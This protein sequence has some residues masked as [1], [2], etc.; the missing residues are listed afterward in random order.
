MLPLCMRL[1]LLPWLFLVFCATA[2]AQSNDNF[3]ARLSLSGIHPIAVSNNLHATRETGEPN[4]AGAAAGRSLWWTWVAPASGV[5]NFCTYNSA[6]TA[7][8]TRA[9]AVYTGDTVSS[10][11]EIA[12]SNNLTQQYYTGNF[13]ISTYAPTAFAGGTSVSVP[14]T[15]GTTYQIAVDALST[16]FHVFGDDGTVVLSIN[17]PPTILSAANVAGTTG[18]GFSYGI[19][20]SNGPTAY[21]ATNLPPGL[22]IN[23]VT[24]VISGTPAAAGTSAIGLSA[25]GPGGTGTANLTLIVSNPV[26]AAPVV[27]VIGSAAAAQGLVGTA[28]SYSIYASG[29]PTAYTAGN[30]PAGLSLAASTGVISGT[31]TAAGVTSVPLSATGPVGTGTATL[32][33]TVANLPP[34]PIVS[35][36]LAASGTTGSS[37]S[38]SI[39]TSG[40]SLTATAATTYTAS[41]LPP[42]LTFSTTSG[43]LSG[44]PTQAGVYPVAFTVTNPGG[45][46]AATV[47]V[48]IADPAPATAPVSQPAPPVLNSNA[49]ATGIVGTAFSYGLTASNTPTSYTA[50]NLPPGFTFDPSSGKFTGT[51][52]TAG[53]F[54]VTVSATNGYGISPG[55]LTITVFASTAAQTA[56]YGLARPVVTSPAA[57]SAPVGQS[58]SY[59]ITAG[60]PGS[61]YLPY[62]NSNW[63]YSATGLPPGLSVTSSTN[64]YGYGTISGTPTTA[65][66]YTATITVNSTASTSYPSIYPAS[67]GTAVVTFTIT[68]TT[69][70]ALPV[71]TVGTDIAFTT[72]SSSYYTVTATGSPT[73]FTAT[74]LPPGLVMSAAGDISGTPT[75]TGTYPATVSATNAVGT[76]SATVTCL[77]TATA[78]PVINGS[79]VTQGTVG[80][81]FGYSI[82]ASNASTGYTASNLPPGLTLNA[83]TGSIN[84][85]PTAAGTYTVPVSATNATGTANVTVTITVVSGVPRVPTIT[86]AAV[87]QATLGQSFYYYIQ[88]SETAT[89]Y[90][91]SN[92]P[93]GLSLASGSNYLTGI[94]TAAGTYTVP[95]SATN[96][97]GTANATLTLIVSP[98][99]VPV[100]SSPAVL[101]LT[102]GQ[103]ISYYN[104]YATNSPTGYTFSGLPPGVTASTSSPGQ[105]TGTPTAAGTYSVGVTATNMT[106]MATATLTITVAP[107]TP[108]AVPVVTSAAGATGIV[109]AAF[110]YATQASVTPTAY[111]I[112]TPPPGL[113]FNTATGVLSGTP[114]AAGTYTFT[115]SATNASGTGSGTV[116]LVVALG[117]ASVPV[118]N[119]PASVPGYYNE[120][121]CYVVTATNSPTSFAAAGLPPGLGFN[122]ATGV[123]S[124]T[125]TTASG[126][127]YAVTLTATNS[128]GSSQATLTLVVL[129]TKSAHL[130]EHIN[131]AASAVFV[132]GRTASYVITDNWTTS[133]FTA[134]PLPP[135]LSFNQSTGV[136]S[137]TP[138]QSG[139]T[140]VSLSASVVGNGTDS[141]LLTIR[142]LPSTNPTTPLPDITSAVGV[143]GYAQMPFAFAVTGTN[144]PTSYAATGLPNGLTINPATGVISG[145]STD[146]GRITATITLANAA[147]S[148]SGTLSFYLLASASPVVALT[149]P[150]A[151][152]GYVGLT[153]SYAPSLAPFSNAWSEIVTNPPP[154][155]S[156]ASGSTIYGV[157]T[158][159]GTYITTV[160][161]DDSNYGKLQTVPVTFTILASAPQPVFVSAAG[162]AGTVGS[163]FSYVPSASNGPSTYTASGLPAGLTFNA[164]NDTI[165]GTPT[166][167]GTFPI[168]L[169][170]TNASGTGNAT[171]TLVVAPLVPPAPTI[172]SSDYLERTLFVGG[173]E[174]NYI[175]TDSGTPTAYAASGLPP[176]LSVNMAPGYISGT[177]TTA[178]TYPVTISASNATG[179]AS[180]VITYVISP[181]S[182]SVTPPVFS[183]LAATRVGYTGIAFASSNLGASGY[184]TSYAATGL[185][186]GLSLDGP[187]GLLTGT[188]TAVGQYTVNL[189]A[190]N[191]AGTGTAVWTVIIRDPSVL[192][193]VFSYPTTA[194]T[195]ATV[196]QPKSFTIYSVFNDG[197]S[198]VYAPTAYTVTGLPP[199]MATATANY[200]TSSSV[201]T[202]SGTPTAAGTFPVTVSATGP[203]NNPARAV[204][205]F[206]VANPAAPTIYSAAGVSGNVNRAFNYSIT[207]GGTVTSYGAGTLPGGLA[208]NTVTGVI[209]GTPTTAGT[210]SVPLMV[211]GAGGTTSGTVTIRIDPPQFGGLPLINSAAAI[212]SQA[213]PLSNYSYYSY[214]PY[215]ASLSLSYAITAINQP[216]SFSAQNLPAGLGLDPATGVISGQPLATGVFQVPISATNAAGT[217]RAVLTIIST[218]PLPVL[219]GSLAYGGYVGGYGG[220]SVSTTL[221]GASPYSYFYASPSYYYPSLGAPDPLQYSATGLPPGLSIDAS[222]GSISGTFTQAGTYPVTISATN[223]AGTGRLVT[224]FAIAA[225]APTGTVMPTPAAPTFYGVSAEALGYV[226]LPLSDTLH[227]TPTASFAASGLPA[228][229]ALNPATGAITG[230][231]PVAGTYPVMVSATN[232]GGTTQA[233]LTIIVESAP[234]APTVTSACAASAN[235]GVSFVYGIY[236]SNY[237]GI[238]AANVYHVGTLPAGLTL[239]AVTGVISGTPMGPTGVF[240]VPLSVSIGTVATTNC[241]LTLSILPAPALPPMPLL[242]SP[243]GSLALIGNPFYYP[244]QS[245]AFAPATALPAGLTYD[246]VAGTIS[247]YPTTPGTYTIPLT[248]SWTTDGTSGNTSLAASAERTRAVHGS[249]RQAAIR[250]STVSSATASTTLTASLALRVA[251]PDLSLPRLL[252]A[253]V[254]GT[255]SEGARMVFTA[256]AVGVP[257]PSYQWRHNGTLISGASDATLVLDPVQPADTG[258]YTVSAIN[259]AGSVTSAVAALLVQTTYADWQAD[260]FTA[261]EIAAGLAAD[262]GEPRR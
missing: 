225:S 143:G 75:A 183:S 199:G 176:G 51:P 108:P 190:T 234:P 197:S 83:T 53:T 186:P 3:A 31:P 251:A 64:P 95:I 169:T 195:T 59:G 133:T 66:T 212:S 12:S 126:A 26:A 49:T 123:I 85:T 258:N 239:N 207:S 106:G 58:F 37:F 262:N 204:I 33:I 236:A 22:E 50:S 86:S 91:A 202:F 141:G 102:V 114:T 25:T 68:P 111:A 113:S 138:T 260:H 162:A 38:Y 67:S 125:P 18:S 177:A 73:S 94:P 224:T 184:P 205:T 175:Y 233:V 228:W 157:P 6:A 35:S 17:A 185:P 248:A 47:T 252:A 246:P 217:S 63:T 109:G 70:G 116:N 112:D 200:A 124:G 178:G 182:A 214:Y 215:V 219:Q 256:S 23:P 155:L 244:L 188:P 229:L 193:P 132:V 213:F 189:S 232:A 14:V 261:Q 43:V 32:T 221:P 4:H 40:S 60:Y 156:Y 16:P 5:V 154:G 148:T 136:I 201:L 180:A 161:I 89:G 241:L 61:P 227:A 150:A 98:P 81:S 77:V 36:A 242:S 160:E 56:A 57:A 97:S 218:A 226:G 90:A 196:G 74:G 107:A 172:S 255:V 238:P 7:P 79:A 163:A 19:A 54:S 171:L 62:S 151:A 243:A 158:T 11:T 13:Y 24:G 122:T 76:A 134:S 140:K 209:S 119:S 170:V 235:L 216:T 120:P 211:T 166:V 1:L 21:A 131:S 135:G 117:P 46:R 191:A 253:P 103:P 231:P 165:T 34:P 42:G 88:T 130:P 142:V 173:S 237:S 181:A 55:T 65:G 28:F 105:L 118:I 72:G 139:V 149:S 187:T 153:L 20:A 100:F 48:T 174:S 15:A 78:L 259:A 45:T 230:T 8:I 137:G 84:G 167:A 144:T 208:L 168:S 29:S 203:G 164:T 71:I 101:A 159:A 210:S 250:R 44:T 82:N 247:G 87:A 206:V 127:S 147:G 222:S 245:A 41:N 129:A 115:V 254:G 93:P 145:V 121:F 146:Y 194:E 257:A 52:T 30:L 192:V 9:L 110:S 92:L 179:S 10:L 198:V 223:R 128:L 220:T 69:T 39:S 152:V 2:R 104:L 99:P 27:P 96:A 80:T 240:T 249:S